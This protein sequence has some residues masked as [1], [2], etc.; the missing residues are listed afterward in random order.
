MVG[1]QPRKFK[2]HK[3]KPNTGKHKTSSKNIDEHI[4]SSSLI[5]QWVYN[6]EY[7]NITNPKQTPENIPHHRKTVTSGI[8]S[9]PDIIDR[10]PLSR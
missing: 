10:N 4:V 3:A 2:Y 5:S 6:Q 9:R 8:T 7:Q 1:L